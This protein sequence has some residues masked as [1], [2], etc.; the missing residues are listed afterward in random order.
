MAI[1][2]GDLL[3]DMFLR[4]AGCWLAGILLALALTGR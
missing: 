1:I 2:A 3:G 4:L